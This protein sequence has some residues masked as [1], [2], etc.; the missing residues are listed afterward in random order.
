MMDALKNWRQHT[1]N[2]R[3]QKK[4][5]QGDET[6]REK[7]EKS[8]TRNNSRPSNKL[9]LFS[10]SLFPPCAWIHSLLLFS[11][12]SPSSSNSCRLL[13]SSENES[14]PALNKISSF[15]RWLFSLFL[16][17]PPVFIIFWLKNFLRSENNSTLDRLY[18]CRQRRKSFKREGS[19]QSQS[20]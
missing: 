6:R 12:L 20:N 11:A 14:F 7:A 10:F 9:S 18:A 4:R 13:I 17:L 8:T 19:V 15:H 3:E 2:R 16:C 1:E 5:E